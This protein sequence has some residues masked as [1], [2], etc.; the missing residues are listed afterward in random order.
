MSQVLQLRASADLALGRTEEAAADINLMLY[1]ANACRDEPIMIS[2]L[3]R[4]AQLKLAIQPIAEGVGQW[5]E[6]QLRAFQERLLRF[7][8]GADMQRALQ[9]ERVFFGGGVIDFLHR[10]PE[11]YNALIGNGD[12][13]GVPGVMW[14]VVPSGWFDFEKL[15]YSRLFENYEMAGLDLPGHRISPAASQR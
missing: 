6:V 1:L 7:D 15:N 3:V 12:G 10:N 9:A 5:S 11:K 4:M 8:F 14:A 13:P 2:Q